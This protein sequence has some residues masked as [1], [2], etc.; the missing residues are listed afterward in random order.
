VCGAFKNFACNCSEQ[1]GK[2]RANAPL[3]L[4]PDAGSFWIM[5]CADEDVDGGSAGT[6]GDGGGGSFF[7]SLQQKKQDK[8]RRSRPTIVG[9]V[10]N[11]PRNLEQV[12][13][14]GNTLADNI[15]YRAEATHSGCQSTPRHGPQTKT[16]K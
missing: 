7:H 12:S 10:V 16:M 11:S 5:K 8:A 14:C 9:S 6:D 13:Q 3:S 15:T 1:V 2:V 4:D